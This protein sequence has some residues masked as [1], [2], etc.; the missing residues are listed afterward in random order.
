MINKNWIQQIINIFFILSLILILVFGIHF[1]NK[2]KPIQKVYNITN[3]NFNTSVIDDNLFELNK[4]V[5]FL[6]SHLNKAEDEVRRLNNTKREIIYKYIE[7]KQ[8]NY[9]NIVEGNYSENQI[10]KV[11]VMNPQTNLKSV[12]NN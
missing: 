11:A 8:D 12:F 2:I 5:R 7:K 9:I 1:F 3:E 10:P 4:R 6:E